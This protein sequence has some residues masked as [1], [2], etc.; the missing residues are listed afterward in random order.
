MKYSIIIPH[1]NRPD[2][3]INTIESFKDLKNK[4]IIIVDD[5]S[6]IENIE[7]LKQNISK[8]NFANNEIKLYESREK[9]YLPGAR[10]KG[11]EL[12]QGEWIYFIDDDDEATPQFIKWL[13]KSKQYKK[14]D[15][16][17]FPNIERLDGKNKMYIFKWWHKKYS[18]QVSTYLFNKAFLKQNKIK[19]NE[20][21][22]YGEDFELMVQIFDLKK[23]KSKYIHCFAFYY[24][25]FSNVDS[26]IRN[27]EINPA[28]KLDAINILLDSK[29][30]NKN[31]Y[32]L[33][34]LVGDFFFSY[35]NKAYSN[36]I[37]TYQVYQSFYEKIKPKFID[38]WNIY[39]PW[40]IQYFSFKKYLKRNKD[41][42]K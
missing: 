1:Y 4:E 25:K 33:S 19:F 36:E 27:K 16:Y 12:A 29:Y 22:L 32:A 11:M 41:K 18:A 10:N 24:N 20:S 37:Q 7:K 21:I 28:N 8:L 6:K 42:F 34:F 9:L 40:K 23:V 17:R 31:S 14:Y 13:N 39:I 35:K 2:L 15:F 5:V 26:M 38:W 3:I 30:K